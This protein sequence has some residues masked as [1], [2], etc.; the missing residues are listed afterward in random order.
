M[1][2]TLTSSN[3]SSCFDRKTWFRPPAEFSQCPFWFWN[4]YLNEAELVRQIGDFKAH[5]VDAFVIHPRIGLPRSLGWLSGELFNFMRIALAEARRRGMW[6]MLYDEGMYPS[7]SAAGLVV[8]RNEAFRVRG[9]TCLPV[10]ELKVA[11][12]ALDRRLVATVQNRSGVSLAVCDERVDA[13]IR[14]LHYQ[15][16][17]NEPNLG[18]DE[19]PAADLLNPEAVRCFIELV[20][21]RFY[22]ELGEYFGNTIKA[23]FTD[24]PHP[25][26]RLRTKNVQPGTTGILDHVNACLGYDF[27]PHLPALWFDD[28]PDAEHYR[29]D[30]TKAIASRLDETYY[31]PLSHWCS[32]H[33]IALTGHPAN[34]DDIGHLRRLHI[35]GQDIVWRHLE[36][37]KPS[38]LEGPPST[39]AKAAASVAF[40]LGRMRNLNEFAGAYGESLTFD[41]LQW[42]A[43]WL[44]IRG[45]NLLVPH[46][47][48]YSMRGPRRLERPPDVGPNNSWWSDYL[49]WAEMTRRLCWLN[50][51]CLPVCHLAI[52]GEATR[53]PWLAARACF[54]NQVDFHYIEPAD[55]KEAEVED[56]YLRV[57]RGR[58]S[59]LVVED[60][61]ETALPSHF[62][63][64]RWTEGGLAEILQRVSRVVEFDRIAP[65]LR[66]RHLQTG[67]G[68]HLFLFFNEG[69]EAIRRR[70]TF[71]VS[72]KI[73]R[74]DP[75]TGE[76][77]LKIHP[78]VVELRPHQWEVILIEPSA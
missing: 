76:C 18:E 29:R 75:V 37:H 2:S 13:V 50:A 6:V 51:T 62:P 22:S 78:E 38:A 49:S 72:G 59:V 23:I 15:G 8:A 42:L 14:G 52:L 45:C 10:D 20:Y 25:L 46:A 77:D 56:G 53:L 3:T 34:P 58:Y 47:F 12:N 1:T 73:W 63:V 19:Y 71:P 16:D 55:L 5:G 66:A 41:E 4:D 7:G 68:G 40:H 11:P 44:L 21:D 54:E 61:Y 30:Y 70:I 17:E 64:V 26:S 27:T 28:E 33:G 69:S 24:E 39:M 65:S 48:Y 43:S 74:L 60:D 67:T 31:M 32:A 57:G 35:P 36:P 9:L